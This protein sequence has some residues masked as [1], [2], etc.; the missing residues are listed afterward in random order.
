ML[1]SLG[2][3]S[4]RPGDINNKKMVVGC[5][6]D[7]NGVEKAFM[8]SSGHCTN[9]SLPVPIPLADYSTISINDR[10]DVVLTFCYD[11][12]NRSTVCIYRYGEYT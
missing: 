6:Q 8:Y 12:G 2:W 11:S 7:N 5:R 10:A 4:V 9:C 3:D 1:P